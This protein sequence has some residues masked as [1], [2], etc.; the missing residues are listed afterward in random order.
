MKTKDEGWKIIYRTLDS[1]YKNLE[2]LLSEHNTSQLRQLDENEKLKICNTLKMIVYLFCKIVEAFE[3]QDIK[4]QMTANAADLTKKGKKTTKRTEESY[5]WQNNKE[6]GFE[7]LVKVF[8]LSI[9]RVFTP[10][11]VED[12]F[13]RYNLLI[14]LWSITN[15][16]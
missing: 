5:D 2:Q 4:A 6:R 13:V 1:L 11:V 16:I 7:V 8:S 15:F 3:D 14:I 10:P 12:E 9:H